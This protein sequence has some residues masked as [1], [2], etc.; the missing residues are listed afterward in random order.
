MRE[1]RTPVIETSA[2]EHGPQRVAPMSRLVHQ[3]VQ[4]TCF[5]EHHSAFTMYCSCGQDFV[6]IQHLTTSEWTLAQDQIREHI[7]TANAQQGEPT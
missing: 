1:K 3:L 7:R 5:Q 2:S 6:H 4:V